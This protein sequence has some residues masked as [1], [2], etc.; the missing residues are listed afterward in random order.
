MY[1]SHPTVRYK[2][3]NNVR[4]VVQ[5]D[6]YMYSYLWLQLFLICQSTNNA[7]SLF[8]NSWGK[9]RTKTKNGSSCESFYYYAH[10]RTCS[11]HPGADGTGR[12]S[13]LHVHVPLVGQLFKLNDSGVIFKL[14]QAH[15][16][17][18]YCARLRARLRKPTPMLEVISSFWR[19]TC[20][21]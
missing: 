13:Q 12:H 8:K 21:D 7:V 14:Y 5:N 18:S 11:P 3:D 6:L 1:Q 2:L 20:A 9:E 15:Q 4:S 10:C 19:S 17:C 16:V